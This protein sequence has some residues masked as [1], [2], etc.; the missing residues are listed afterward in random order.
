MQWHQPYNQSHFLRTFSFIATTRMQWN[1][2][3]TCS[4]QQREYLSRSFPY[5]LAHTQLK[6]DESSGLSDH[7]VKS[8]GLRLQNHVTFSV[9]L[10][11]VA[12]KC[13]TQVLWVLSQVTFLLIHC[14]RKLQ[15]TS[16]SYS[17][18]IFVVFYTI[19]T[20]WKALRTA[21]AQVTDAAINFS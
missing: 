8:D 14:M 20:H 2:F 9:L 21:N 3:D 12:C 4:T 19:L 1:A 17:Y 11:S 5:N 18:Q 6:H 16:L 7:M 13:S 10:H 15:V